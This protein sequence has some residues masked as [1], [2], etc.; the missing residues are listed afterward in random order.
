MATT[1]PRLGIPA[2][3]LEARRGRLLDHARR[4]RLES[5]VARKG[6]REAPPTGERGRG[7]APAHRLL[8]E[9]TRP[10]ATEAEASLRAAQEATLAMLEALGDTGG[11]GSADGVKA[12]YRGQI[13]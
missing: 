6:E 3:E 13:G 7:G 2:D 1:R 12:G 5:M 11:L 8:Q 4:E 9:Y 10:G